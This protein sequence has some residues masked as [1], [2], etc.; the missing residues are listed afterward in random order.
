M[1][2]IKIVMHADVQGYIQQFT[3][4][5]SRLKINMLDFHHA[6]MQE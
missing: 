4:F 1:S 6:T 2:I 5:G 3:L